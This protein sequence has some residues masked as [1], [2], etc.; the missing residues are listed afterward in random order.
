MMIIGSGVLPDRG[1]DGD[2]DR[3]HDGDGDRG[4]GRGGR[5]HN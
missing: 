1:G 2:G 4:R 5:R 3:G